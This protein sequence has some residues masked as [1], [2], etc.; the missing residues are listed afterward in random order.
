MPKRLRGTRP[1]AVGKI[2]VTRYRKGRRWRP[3]QLTPG[4]SILELLRHTVAARTQTKMALEFLRAV[5]AAAPALK[6]VRGETDGLIDALLMEGNR[7]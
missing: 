6:G 1:L 5:A 2:V 4:E 3:R 7:A